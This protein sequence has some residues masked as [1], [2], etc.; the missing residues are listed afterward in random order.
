MALNP[1]SDNRR[2]PRQQWASPRTRSERSSPV[3]VRVRNERPRGRHT[4]DKRDELA[5]L[6]MP[7]E[8]HA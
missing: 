3:V 6:H 4:A 8:D 5:P 7:R 2:E 1:I